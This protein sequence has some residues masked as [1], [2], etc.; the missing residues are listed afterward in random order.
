MSIFVPADLTPG[1]LPSGKGVGIPLSGTER[2]KGV[3]PVRSAAKAS[4][5]PAPLLRA[6]FGASLE[7]G[8]RRGILISLCGPNGHSRLPLN[9]GASWLRDNGVPK[10]RRLRISWASYLYVGL[11]VPL[12]ASSN[13]KA[14]AQILRLRL[15]MTAMGRRP[16]G[17][18]YRNDAILSS[19]ACWSAVND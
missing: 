18:P 1:P 19:S 16:S 10:H 15:R 7:R 4:S 13:A 2:G 12:G 17:A 11:L 8:A 9:D 5:P 14:A 3:R 6:S